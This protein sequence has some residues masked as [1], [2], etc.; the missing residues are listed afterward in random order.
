MNT[1][2]RL[3]KNKVCDLFF[4][5]LSVRLD[6]RIHRHYCFSVQECM[7]WMRYYSAEDYC[8]ITAGLGTVLVAK[9]GHAV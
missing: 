4:Y 7:E 1:L 9:R 6:D 2:Y 8:W 5:T 3:L